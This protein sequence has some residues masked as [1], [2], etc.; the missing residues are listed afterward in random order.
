MGP[1]QAAPTSSISRMTRCSMS[2]PGYQ[3]EVQKTSFCAGTKRNDIF[4]M[5]SNIFLLFWC[6]ASSM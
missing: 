3:H 1:I 6:V 5:S 2:K 4:S